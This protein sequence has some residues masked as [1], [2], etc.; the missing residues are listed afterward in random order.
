METNGLPT[1]DTVVF[2][3][4]QVLLAEKRTALSVGLGR[5][6]RRD[7][8]QELEFVPPRVEVRDFVARRFQLRLQLENFRARFR[9]E[10]RRGK[11]GLQVRYLV[12]CRENIRLYRRPFTLFFPLKL[13]RFVFAPPRRGDGCGR[14][15][16]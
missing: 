10:I 2:N 7:A 5:L 3:E 9:I 12:F 16:F 6:G 11:R 15:G 13:P 8:L 1:P 14:R 4:I